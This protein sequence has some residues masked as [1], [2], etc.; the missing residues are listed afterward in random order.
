LSH[1]IPLALGAQ[2]QVTEPKWPKIYPTYDVTHKK[3]KYTT[4]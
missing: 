4:L 1:K 2:G 3:T